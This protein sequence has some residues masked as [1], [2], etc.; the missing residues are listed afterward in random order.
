MMNQFM[1]TTEN[2]SKVLWE[3]HQKNQEPFSKD[4]KLN[5]LFKMKK[6][7]LQ[8]KM[9]KEWQVLLDKSKEN[10]KHLKFYQKFL[11]FTK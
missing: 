2:S 4:K 9:H 11:F 5:L 7:Y 6:N 3:I 1:Y 8:K 10:W